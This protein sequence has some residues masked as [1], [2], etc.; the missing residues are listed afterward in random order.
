MFRRRNIILAFSV[1]AALVAASACGSSG[2]GSASGSGSGSSAATPT[3]NVTVSNATDAFV[4]PWLVGQKEGFFK[5]A[6]VNV[7]KIVEGKGGTQS[8]QTQL[9]GDIP[10]GDISF[11]GVTQAIDQGAP[12]VAVAGATQ[13]LNGSSFYALAGNTSIKTVRD[14]K[15]WAYTNPGS[16]SQALTYM[17]PQK[18]GIPDAGVKRVAS[19]GTGEGIALLESHKVDVTVIGQA[20]ILSNPGK[21]RLVVSPASVIGSFQQS[22]IT[23][24]KSYLQSHGA[25]VKSVVAG[26]NDAVKWIPGHVDQAAALYATQAGISVADAKLVVESCVK[27]LQ[28]GAAI[29]DKALEA[30][31]QAIRI[32]GF[33][34]KIDYCAIFNTSYLPAGVSRTLPKKC[35][36]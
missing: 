14:I 29:N 25:I 5:K 27:A 35:G 33:K 34:G 26:Y 7:S 21:Y 3:I 32:G 20:V 13:S 28:W 8:L 31:A 10:I 1:S 2:S 15:T 4:I 9:S 12:V 30:S 23:T 24:T 11:T 22:V 36:S 19:G 16:V 17:I 18:E 6:G